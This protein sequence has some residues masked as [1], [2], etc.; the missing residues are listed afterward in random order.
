MLLGGHRASSSR[1]MLAFPNRARRVSQLRA[2]A[3]VS[4]LNSIGYTMTVTPGV[5]FALQPTAFVLDT[6]FSPSANRTVTI[7]ASEFPNFFRPWETGGKTATHHLRGQNYALLDGVTAITDANG[8]ATWERLTLIA[9]SSKFLY[10][11]FYCD[12]RHVCMRLS[13][14]LPDIVHAHA[15]GHARRQRGLATVRSRHSTTSLQ[16]RAWTLS[17][18]RQ[19][20]E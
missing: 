19:F 13:F 5:P 9:S 15:H 7:F 18:C 11:F 14:S 10:L 16:R 1:C 4:P 3:Q 20:V 12:V 8:V 2:P 17:G 6:Q